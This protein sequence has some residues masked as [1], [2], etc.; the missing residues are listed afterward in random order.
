METLKSM[1]LNQFKELMGVDTLDFRRPKDPAKRESIYAIFTYE[2]E[3]VLVGTS[4]NGTLRADIVAGTVKHSQL[5]IVEPEA[6]TYVL[7]Y[8]GG[9]ILASI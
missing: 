8:K 2:D 5:Q 6:G 3:N 9:E 7:C 1:S 4:K